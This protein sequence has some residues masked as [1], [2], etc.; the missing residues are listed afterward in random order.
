MTEKG[1]G[2]KKYSKEAYPDSLVNGYK[3]LKV[4][5]WSVAMWLLTGGVYASSS[6]SSNVA[7][8]V[9]RDHKGY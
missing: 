8:Y 9:H 6:S 5:I 7:A 3:N 1:G 4:I 2:E